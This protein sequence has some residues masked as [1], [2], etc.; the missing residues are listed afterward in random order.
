VFD[1][2]QIEQMQNEIKLVEDLVI[3]E[4]AKDVK[5]LKILGLKRIYAIA[6]KPI[7]KVAE[8]ISK[9][10]NSVVILT[11]FDEHGSKIA[12]LL[13]QILI[14]YGVKINNKIRNKFKTVFG[15]HKIE[16][17]KSYTKFMEENYYGKAL[18]IHNKIFNRIRI[19]NRRVGRKT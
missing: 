8:E 6:G 1:L 18:P 4:G 7:H 11:D 13:S 9:H 16:E 19:F 14:S 3:V 15:V 10:Y 5:Q 12:N 17:I 2:K